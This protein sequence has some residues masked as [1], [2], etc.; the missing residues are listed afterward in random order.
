MCWLEVKT[1]HKITIFSVFRD[2]AG[3]PTS[4]FI[5]WSWVSVMWS[6]WSRVNVLVEWRLTRRRVEP[7]F[8][9]TQVQYDW[10][11]MSLSDWLKLLITDVWLVDYI[12]GCTSQGLLSQPDTSVTRDC[13]AICKQTS[14][15]TSFTVGEILLIN[16]TNTVMTTYHW[17]QCICILHH[18]WCDETIMSITLQGQSMLSD[19]CPH[20]LGLNQLKHSL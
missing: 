2:I 1:I 17:W 3:L 6:L 10:L 9:V 4:G 19:E 11:I 12:S 20:S 16:K 14:S 18:Q 8:S 13:I 15:C 5:C 7:T